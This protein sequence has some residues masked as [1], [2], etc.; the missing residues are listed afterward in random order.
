[1]LV[2][3]EVKDNWG[4]KAELNNTR[5]VYSLTVARKP[6]ELGFDDLV[7][8]HES[9]DKIK[10]ED[11]QWVKSGPPGVASSLWKTQRAGGSRK[12]YIETIE[13]DGTTRIRVRQDGRQGGRATPANVVSQTVLGGINSVDFPHALA[14]KEEMRNWRFLRL[15]PDHLREPTRKDIGMRDTITPS[16]EN[17]AA[18]PCTTCIKQWSETRPANLNLWSS[19]LPLLTMRPPNPH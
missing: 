14:A 18:G 19:N 17:L 1:M 15:N 10:N 8:K 3:R 6:N 7:V 13:Q 11:D 12:P 5:L 16:G 2:N 9:L 4:G